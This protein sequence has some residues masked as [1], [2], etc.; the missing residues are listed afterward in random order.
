MAR[1]RISSNQRY[2]RTGVLA[3]VLTADTQQALRD[4]E[5]GTK[6][7]TGCQLACNDLSDVSTHGTD[8][9]PLRQNFHP[10]GFCALGRDSIWL[11]HVGIF[12]LYGETGLHKQK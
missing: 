5:T 11:P 6:G 10:L 8:L 12:F 1:R 7:Q 9:R 3:L 2:I 4:L